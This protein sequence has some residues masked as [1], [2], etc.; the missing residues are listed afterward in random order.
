MRHLVAALAV[1]F[2]PVAV[3]AQQPEP[4]PSGPVLTLEE[5]VQLALRNNPTHLQ[6]TTQRGRAGTA[7]RSAY[8]TLLPTLSSDAGMSF[9]AGGTEQFAG[10]T[11]GASSDVVSSSYGL[12]LTANYSAASIMEPR[13]ARANLDAAEASVTASGQTTRNLIAQQYLTALQAQARAALADTLLTNV[14]AQLELARARQQVGAATALDVRTAEVQVG[15]QQVALLQARNSVEIETLR[16]FQQI[17]LE[18]PDGVRLTTTFPMAE[19]TLQLQELLDMARRANPSLNAARSRENAANVGVAV[20]RSRWIPSV[21]FRTGWS[22]FT[23]KQTNIAP[24]LAQAQQSLAG[25]RRSCYTTDS[26]RVGAGLAPIG[27]DCD[28]FVFTPDL[29]AALRAEN[30]RYPFDFT[31]SPFN[32]SVGVSLPIFDGFR[33]E[34]QIQDAQFARNDARYARRAEE[35]RINT[36]VT[37]AHRNLTTAY[38]TVRINEQ[39]QQ[40][41]REAL[42]LAQTRYRVGATTFLEVTQSRA[43]FEQ[44]ATDLINSIYDF[45]KAYAVLE[46]AVGRP[47]R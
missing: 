42:E 10:Q 20:A 15:R 26:I 44:A 40:A 31:K 23:Q 34:Q 11:I 45:H 2:A 28:R 47:L 39:N 32:Y 5:A 35:L 30:D 3:L 27:G 17:G 4:Q 21:G 16:L 33:R 1:A 46:A 14:Q 13:R 41:A 6:S 19:P 37:S 22:G 8:G 36:D 24:T 18:K 29:E 38:Q 9:R 25:Q 7:L 12:S 43:T